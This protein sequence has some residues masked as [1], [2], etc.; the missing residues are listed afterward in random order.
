MSKFK[1][2]VDIKN[3]VIELSKKKPKKISVASAGD[4]E[5]LKTIKMS[6]DIGLATG[7]LIGEREE[8][9]KYADEIGLDLSIN[10]IV[11]VSGEKAIAEKAVEKVRTGEADM[12][13][14]GLI[15]SPTFMRAILNSQT[16]IKSG[17]FVHLVSAVYHPSL[18]KIRLFSDLGMVV[19]P[20]LNEKIEMIKNAS[21]VAIKMGIEKPKV[22]LLAAME[23]VSEKISVTNECAIISKMA[24]RAQI[25]DVIVDGPLSFD[26]ACFKEA[27]ERK[28]YE[29]PIQGDA[30][31]LIM[32]N[33]HAGNIFYKSAVYMAGMETGSNF[34]GVKKPIAIFSRGD[35]A[36]AKLNSI[37]F[38]LMLSE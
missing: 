38:A 2:F 3:H 7:I 36:E 12:L 13:M 15:H 26:L 30:D 17:G 16:G 4:I 37:A 28:R 14:K 8:I 21:E 6:N 20:T 11:D 32:P 10:T 18:S 29:G 35:T 22:A 34:A 19:E 31:V 1:D 27:C 5:V 23:T 33:L 9:T 25:G 24:D